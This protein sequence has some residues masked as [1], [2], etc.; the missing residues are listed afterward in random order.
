MNVRFIERK[1]KEKVLDDLPQGGKFHVA[2]VSDGRSGDSPW[3]PVKP[4]EHFK[5][6]SRYRERDEHNQQTEK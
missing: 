6:L 1:Q 2:V 3:L 5:G 4:R